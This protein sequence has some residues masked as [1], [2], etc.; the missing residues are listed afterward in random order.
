MLHL[1][2]LQRDAIVG[3]AEAIRTQSRKPSKAHTQVMPA[4]QRR[5]TTQYAALCSVAPRRSQRIADKE[6]AQAFSSDYF[7]HLEHSNFLVTLPFIHRAIHFFVN[8][9]RSPAP[10]L[11]CAHPWLVQ[12]PVCPCGHIPCL[13]TRKCC[14][15]CC[16]EYPTCVSTSTTCHCHGLRPGWAPVG[17]PCALVMHGWWREAHGSVP[18]E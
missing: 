2:L 17:R 7:E 1:V 6:H 8:P 5:P 12:D 9:P 14:C 11:S 10:T 15:C 13:H 4:Y 18:K 16:A 3:H